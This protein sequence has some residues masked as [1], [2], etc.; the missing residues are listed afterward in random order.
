MA[1][2][3]TAP[4]KKFFTPEQ[5]NAML[6]LVSRI[7][8]D[9]ADL[10]HDLRDRH[11]RL[12][13]LTRRPGKLDDAAGDELALIETELERGRERMRE[14]EYELRPLGVLLK[15][16]FSG[17]LDFPCWK[18]DREIYLC[19]KLGEPEVAHWHEI[20]TG[21]AGRQKLMTEARTGK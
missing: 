3:K 6:P 1:R 14:L 8:R 13:R 15:D 9:I 21:F 19:W 2:K 5:A 7:V 4:R 11:Q 16:Y 12:E 10:A 20:D 18:D 17:L